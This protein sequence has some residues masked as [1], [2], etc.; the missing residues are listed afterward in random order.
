M[1][2]SCALIIM[3]TIIMVVC[4]A[5]A[6]DYEITRKAGDLTVNIRIDK[7]PPVAGPNNIEVNITDASGKAVTDAKVLLNYSM[8]AMPGM[9]AMNYKADL[10]PAGNVYRAKI[11]YSMSGSW[12]NDL[13]VTRAGKT[14][15]AKFSVDA[16]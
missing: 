1:K 13:K 9:P 3:L 10:V 12:N 8:P 5:Y 14:V 4:V 6:K 11:D 16:R 7:N 2:R 15:S